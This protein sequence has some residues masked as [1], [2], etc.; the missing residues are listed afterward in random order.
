MSRKVAIVTDSTGAFPRSIIDELNLHIVPLNIHW[1]GKNYVDFVDITPAEFYKMLPAAKTLPTTSQPSAAAFITVFEQLIAENYDI[2]TLPLSSKISGTYDSAM[3]AL[4]Q[5][6]AGRVEVL[7]TLLASIP[8][9][10]IVMK[11]ARA[12]KQ[13]ATLLECSNIAKEAASRSKVF[14]AVETL[15]YLHKGGRINTAAAFLGTALNLKPILSLEDGLIVPVDRVR[16]TRKAHQHLLDLAEQS[17]GSHGKIEF[18][19]LVSADAPKAVEELRKEA[20]KRFQIEEE[21]ATDLSP[22]L[23]C[24]VGN[25][26]VGLSF[27][28]G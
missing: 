1:D 20:H 5:V 16:T 11:T 13:G 19:G 28:A 26:A 4:R 25:G 8:L 17:V 14:F 7:D 27:M 3:M 22:V 21:L 10:A 24:H 15:E 18:L 2:L 9:S 12:A 23:G 6:T